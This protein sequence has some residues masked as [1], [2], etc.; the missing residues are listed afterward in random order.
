[1][2]ARL[3][4]LLA[5]LIDPTSAFEAAIK[6]GEDSLKTGNL[7]TARVWIERALERDSK[8][9]R[10]WDLRARWAE[11][12]KDPDEQVY[13][14]HQELRLLTSQKAPAKDLADLRARVVAVDA[15]AN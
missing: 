11:A 6:N 13:A 14:L 9:P 4:L 12:A 3:V 8:S 1:M 2:R 10:A 5:L 7:A 15:N